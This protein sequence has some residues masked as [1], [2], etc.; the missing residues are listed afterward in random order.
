MGR[1]NVR[2]LLSGAFHPKFLMIHRFSSDLGW[3]RWSHSADDHV[4][5]HPS[6]PLP[7]SLPTKG[8]DNIFVCIVAV[9]MTPIPAT[10]SARI[11]SHPRVWPLAPFLACKVPREFS[12]TRIS[13]HP[14]V[15]RESH[16]DKHEFRHV[17]TC[18]RC[19]AAHSI[20]SF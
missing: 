20:G 10:C 7:R 9:T 13:L 17:L 12:E 8:P 14:R 5:G 15:W 16:W 2:P 18:A 6:P 19:S 11:S 3:R 1:R 4:P